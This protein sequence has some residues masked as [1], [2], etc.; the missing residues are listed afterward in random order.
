MY[1]AM[2]DRFMSGWGRAEGKTNRLVIECGS[3]AQ[4]EEIM[5]V[6][7]KRPE[8]KRITLCLHKPRERPGQLITWRH[9]GQM[10]G[11]RL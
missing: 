3:H 4:A 7:R 2:T 9:Y 6:A 8:M 1:V 11:W 5:A 10:I